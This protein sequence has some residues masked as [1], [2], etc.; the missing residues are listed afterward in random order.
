MDTDDYD[1][2]GNRDPR[3]KGYY[4]YNKKEKEKLKFPAI[5]KRYDEYFEISERKQPL[6]AGFFDSKTIAYANEN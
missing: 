4:E 3:K 5:H 6:F 2:K 1:D